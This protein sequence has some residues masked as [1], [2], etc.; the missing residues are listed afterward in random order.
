MG[1]FMHCNWRWAGQ[2]RS[3][4]ICV[5]RYF[6]VGACK[7]NG[8]STNLDYDLSHDGADRFFSD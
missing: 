8:R 3:G 5:Y 4:A 6:G 7:F 2:P 1:R